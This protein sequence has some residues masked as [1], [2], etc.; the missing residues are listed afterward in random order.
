MI[1]ASNCIIRVCTSSSICTY[2]AL[3]CA[4]RHSL[5]S[6]R[7]SILIFRKACSSICFRLPPSSRWIYLTTFLWPGHPLC[8]KLWGTHT[9]WPEAPRK[10]PSPG[11]GWLR[12]AGGSLG[13]S[14]PGSPA[15]HSHTR[16]GSPRVVDRTVEPFLVF[17][18]P[19]P[20]AFWSF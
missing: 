16:D 4:R 17:G 8:K 6:V 14:E 9:E 12:R 3:G 11:R 5:I 15:L 2:V 13:Q 20:A 10:T 1:C 19:C 7:I 18:G